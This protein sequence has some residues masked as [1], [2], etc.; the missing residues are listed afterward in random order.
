MIF[1]SG[2]VRTVTIISTDTIGT[3]TIDLIGAYT[4]RGLVSL[5][6]FGTTTG[7]SFGNSVRIATFVSR[8]IFFYSMARKADLKT[9]E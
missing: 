7:S 3:V 4:I 9:D 1:V 5:G 6:T 2:A 8:R